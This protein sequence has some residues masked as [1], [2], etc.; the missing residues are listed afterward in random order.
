MTDP[1]TTSMEAR[2]EALQVEWSGVR[3]QL[4]SHVARWEERRAQL[5]EEEVQLRD[6]GRWI[7]GRSDY[8]GVLG[9]ERDELSHSRMIAWLLDPCARHGL[10]SRVLAGLISTVFGSLAVPGLARAITRCEELL[11]DGRLDVVVR[12]PGLH[13]VIENKV[14]AAEDGQCQYYSEHLPAE[15]LCVLLSP[16]GRMPADKPSQ[17]DDG[18]PVVVNR[19]KPLRYSE[20]ADILRAALNSTPT[21]TDGRRIAEDYLLTLDMELYDD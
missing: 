14:D 2:F 13:L 4:R 9:R 6:T 7:H 15:A 18:R 16:D 8:L 19:F 5:A 3:H 12:A 17:A 10:G 11:V 21:A 20:F 1:L